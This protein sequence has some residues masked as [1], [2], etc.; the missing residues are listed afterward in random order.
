L[1]DH[2]RIA[3]A[4]CLFVLS[5]L[6]TTPTSR[7]ATNASS[8]TKTCSHVE[9]TSLR[10]FPVR[11]TGSALPP[12]I[13]VFPL[14][15]VGPT[16]SFEVV[17]AAPVRVGFEGTGVEIA[18]TAAG[19]LFSEKLV[20]KPSQNSEPPLQY[21]IEAEL[22]LLQP[23]AL[24]QAKWWPVFAI[25]DRITETVAVEKKIIADDYAGNSH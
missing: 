14:S 7:A 3:K 15:H 22:V 13:S 8:I 21:T 23:E 25:S 17:I 12:E 6:G 19:V 18:C 16:K 24:V 9:V 1:R 10:V 20:W 11:E 5:L 4:L 2:I